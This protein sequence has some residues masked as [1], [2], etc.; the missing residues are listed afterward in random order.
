MGRDAHVRPDL[1]GTKAGTDYTMSIDI[2]KQDMKKYD[3][4]LK[5]P[6]RPKAEAPPVEAPPDPILTEEEMENAELIAAPGGNKNGLPDDGEKIGN[7]FAGLCRRIAGV[8]G[9]MTDDTGGA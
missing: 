3:T 4:V 5:V 1:K 6:P 9:F 8:Q 2:A 7:R